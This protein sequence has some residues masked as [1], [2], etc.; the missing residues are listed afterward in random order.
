MIVHTLDSQAILALPPGSHIILLSVDPKAS[1]AGRQLGLTLR[2]TIRIVGPGQE[3]RLAFL[4]R[5]PLEG[6]V[7]ENVLKYGVGGIN[8]DGCR[9]QHASPKDLEAH[10]AMVQAIK[11]RGGSMANSWKNSS[12]LAGANEVSS[13]GRWPP[14]L[15]FVHGEECRRD[16]FKTVKTGTAYE[17]KQMLRKVFGATNTLGRTVGFATEPGKETVASWQ[18]QAGCPV[19]ALDQQSGTTKESRFSLSGTRTERPNPVYGKPN[20]TRH[21]PDA[22]GDSGGSSR[23]FPQFE[24]EAQLFAWLQT[25]IGSPPP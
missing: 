18:C 10:K 2:D 7:A 12:D 8:I 9:V 4:L 16:G 20:T 25:L 23:F 5:K 11:N 3:Q 24:N 14:N 17:P 21:A 19:A 22:Y 13:A 1:I 15:V 6:T